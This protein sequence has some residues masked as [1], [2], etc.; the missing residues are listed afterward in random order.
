MRKV[1]FS[2]MALMLGS[3]M[4]RWRVISGRSG[5]LVMAWR[6]PLSRSASRAWTMAN[7]LEYVLEMGFWVERGET[8]M[9]L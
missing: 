7:S 1:R 5:M 9:K 6:G 8:Y 2:P 4:W 3:E